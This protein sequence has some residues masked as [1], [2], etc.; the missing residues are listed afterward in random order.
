MVELDIERYAEF[1]RKAKAAKRGAHWFYW[2]AGLTLI[3][4]IVILSGGE[5]AFG[6]GLVLTQLT[7][8]I[9]VE[10]TEGLGLIPKIFA[11]MFALAATGIFIVLGIF[12][13]RLKLA[14]FVV[15]MVLFGLDSVLALVGLLVLDF[16]PFII[17][18][19]AMLYLFKGVGNCRD[20]NAMGIHDIRQL[21]EQSVDETLQ[22]PKPKAA[23]VPQPV[24]QPVPQ[25]AARPG[26]QTVAHASIPSAPVSSV[27]ETPAPAPRA[28]I[29]SH[30]RVAKK[31]ALPP[32]LKKAVDERAAADAKAEEP[33]SMEMQAPVPLDAETPAP[34]ET[35]SEPEESKPSSSGLSLTRR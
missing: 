22:K 29:T 30:P 3:N 7:D 4:S 6:L 26:P 5:W 8:A 35:V 19:V 18:V 32:H 15:G 1:E 13:S 34:A 17:H 20:L 11:F 9:A 23:S 27:A 25:G 31:I 2:I 33:P 21:D 12:A 28:P 14:G 16:I 24:P 10:I